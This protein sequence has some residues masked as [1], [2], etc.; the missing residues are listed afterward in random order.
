MAVNYA[1]DS[2]ATSCRQQNL[3]GQILNELSTA[4][5]L[6]TVL[7]PKSFNRDFY[8]NLIFLIYALGIFCLDLIDF[9]SSTN[10]LSYILLGGLHL[11]SAWLYLRAWQARAWPGAAVYPEIMNIFAAALY[12]CAAGFY[13]QAHATDDPASQLVNIIELTAA[14]TDLIACFGWAI[15]CQMAP[16][17]RRLHRDAPRFCDLWALRTSLAGAG[18]YVVY[19]C[20]KLLHPHSEAINRLYF[21]ADAFYVF[22]GLLYFLASLR[23]EGVADELWLQA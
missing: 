20:Q 5:V 10:H 23:L 2:P 12:L 14:V 3:A 11:G 16:T 21:S 15:T 22:A 13:G 1:V 9:S 6:K 7:Q 8:A 19:Y 4:T 18:L 17:Q